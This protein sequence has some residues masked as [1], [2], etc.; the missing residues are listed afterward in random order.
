METALEDFFQDCCLSDLRQFFAPCLTLKLDCDGKSQI[1]HT[2]LT[3]SEIPHQC[4]GGSA[5]WNHHQIYPHWWIEITSNQ[6]NRYQI[7]YALNGPLS[8]ANQKFPSGIFRLTE[9]PELNYKGKE[10]E[11]L[12]LNM[13]PGLFEVTQMDLEHQDRQNVPIPLISLQ[14]WRKHNHSHFGN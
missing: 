9:A 11:V 7:D 14:E 10:T 2:I 6:G 1:I 5:Y 3:L 12:Q 8:P 4:Y 13:I